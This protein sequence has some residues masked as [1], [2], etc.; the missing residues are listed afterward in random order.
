MFVEMKL[1][2]ITINRNNSEGLRRT[3]ESVVTQTYT[4]FEYIVIDGASTDESVAI[5]RRYEN[6]IAYWVSEPDKGIYDAMNK[7]I[8]QAHGEYCLFMNSGDVFY[9]TN[10]LANIQW[11]YI[12]EDIVSGNSVFEKSSLHDERIIISPTKIRAGNLILG[13]LP[14]QSTFIKTDLFKTVGLYDVDFR[15]VSDWLFFIK[16]LLVCNASYRHIDLFISRCE[17]EGVSNNPANCKLMDD[18]FHLGLKKVLPYYYED[19][20][21][22]KAYRREKKIPRNIFLNK[23]SGTFFFKLIWKIYRILN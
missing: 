22:L 3:I 4:D 12:N 20:V 9:D 21:E 8:L 5:I 1:S 16:A 17:T 19:M 23:F 6:K 2:I 14:H 11:G 15:I 13:F 7:G 18:E 10:T